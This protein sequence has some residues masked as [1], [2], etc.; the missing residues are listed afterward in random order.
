MIADALGDVGAVMV[1][2]RDD[3]TFGAISSPSLNAM[4]LDAQKNF[5]GQDFR[6][7]RGRERGIFLERDAVTDRHVASDD[8]IDRHPFYKF[9]ESHGLRYFAG[10]PMSPD[11]RVDM[12]IALQRATDRLPYSDEELAAVTELGRHAEKSMRLSIQLLD[13]EIGRSGLQDA[14]SRLNIGVFAIDPIKRIVFSNEVAERLIGDGIQVINGRLYFGPDLARDIDTELER[15]IKGDVRTASPRPL[16]IARKR[17]EHP[18]VAYILPISE[19]SSLA[20]NFLTFTR[21]IVL[22]ID[23]GRDEPPDPA[24]VRD[25]LNLTLGEARVAS[26]VGYG[27]SPRDAAQ[28]LGMTEESARTT[29]KRVFGKIGVSR[30]SEL[31]ILIGRLTLKY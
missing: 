3:G 31:A 28:K 2:S 9:M 13:A 25:V 21:A 29:L 19:A 7:I 30:Q 12:A 27:L 8:E 24:V 23:S 14:L 11:P 6:S 10:V 20:H 4:V 1:Y 15:M 22:V 18:L 16:I 5:Q 26:L 17:N